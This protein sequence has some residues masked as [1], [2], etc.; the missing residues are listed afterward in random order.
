MSK[1]MKSAIFC[2]A[3]SRHWLMVTLPTN[4]PMP[5]VFEPFSILAAF[6]RK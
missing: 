2:F 1:R 6:F 3:I 4:E 5:V